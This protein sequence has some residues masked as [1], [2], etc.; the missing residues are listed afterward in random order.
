MSS[1]IFSL[2]GRIQE[3][4]GEDSVNTKEAFRE[5]FQEGFGEREGNLKG[6]RSTHSVR[7]RKVRKVRKAR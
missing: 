6:T 1:T 3:T 5:D 7:K 4:F 2:E